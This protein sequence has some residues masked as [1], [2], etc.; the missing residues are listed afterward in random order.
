MTE[1]D[2]GNATLGLTTTASAV[3]VINEYAT[4]ISLGLTIIGLIIGFVFHLLDRIHKRQVA[5]RNYSL[6]KERIRQEI[7][8]EIKVNKE[9]G[10]E[11]KSKN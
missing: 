5:D 11:T 6:E 10:R 7:L 9:Q 4:I 1:S 8:C 2:V 3:A